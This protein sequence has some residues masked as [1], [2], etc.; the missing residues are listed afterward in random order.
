MSSIA[1]IERRGKTNSDGQ[2]SEQASC[3]LFEFK[4]WFDDDCVDK[5]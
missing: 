5:Q 4:P 3:L 1:P 2:K